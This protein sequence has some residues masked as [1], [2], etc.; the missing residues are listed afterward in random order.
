MYKTTRYLITGKLLFSLAECP[1]FTLQ[2]NG[3]NQ[4]TTLVC[5][6]TGGYPPITNISLLKNG[7]T[8]ASTVGESRLQV[9]TTDI[10]HNINRYGMYLCLVNLSGIPLQQS[11][12]LKERGRHCV[13]TILA[14]N[15]L[16]KERAYDPS[17]NHLPHFR[18][19]M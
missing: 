14:Q 13:I 9:N 1:L 5:S 4:N 19:G 15:Q 18:I 11:V 8:I 12:L 2:Q 6:A 17:P 10:S 16:M 3:Q 7:Q